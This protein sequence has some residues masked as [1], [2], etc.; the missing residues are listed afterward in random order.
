M[1]KLVDL[2]H[3]RAGDAKLLTVSLKGVFVAEMT[4]NACREG[5]AFP[6]GAT[7][8]MDLES[9]WTEGPG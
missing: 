8:V 9:R 2:H 5:L 6:S 7:S 3:I 4:P 1:L